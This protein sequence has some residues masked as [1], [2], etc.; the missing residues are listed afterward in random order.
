MSGNVVSVLNEA[1]I[2][3]DRST[4]IKRM[5]RVDHI[6]EPINQPTQTPIIIH[7]FLL[8]QIIHFPYCLTNFESGFLLLEGRNISTDKNNKVSETNFAESSSSLFGR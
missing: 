2:D 7:D 1:N 3:D 8:Y 5:Q 6:V 4:E